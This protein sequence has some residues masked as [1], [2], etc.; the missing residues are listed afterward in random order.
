MNTVTLPSGKKVQL[1]D[2]NDITERQRRPLSKLRAKLAANQ[3]VASIMQKHEDGKKLTKA[4]EASIEA[5][6]GDLLE[7]V[8][9]MGDRLIVAAVAG[10]DHPFPVD[11]D[12]VLDLPARD[13]DKLREV[14]AP[15]MGEL[16]PDFS[17]T[18]DKASP[19][20]V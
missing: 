8:E 6:L 13:L 12:S 17:P 9:E 16:F 1:R 19:T 18:V 20:G 7:V 11:Y 3:E 14:C 10:W 2:V 15:Y 4:E 5:Q